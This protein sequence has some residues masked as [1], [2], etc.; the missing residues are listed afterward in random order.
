MADFP[1]EKK[2]RALAQ[3]GVD[4]TVEARLISGFEMLPSGCFAMLVHINGSKSRSIPT[5]QEGIT[6]GRQ[7]TDICVDDDSLSPEHSRIFCRDGGWYVEAWQ[8]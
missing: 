6:I 2:R 4:L 1:A 7:E 8:V 3:T 5:D